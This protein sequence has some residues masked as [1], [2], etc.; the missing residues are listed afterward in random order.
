MESEGCEEDELIKKLKEI[1]GLMIKENVL[2]VSLSKSNLTPIEIYRYK[3]IIEEYLKQELIEIFNLLYKETDTF[4]K[5]DFNIISDGELNPL[6]VKGYGERLEL[7]AINVNFEL[8][9]IV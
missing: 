3:G 4:L 2:G 7:C 1:K 8:T 9:F 5:L 6:D